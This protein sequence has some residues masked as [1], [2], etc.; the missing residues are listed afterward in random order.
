MALDVV[1]IEGCYVSSSLPKALYVSP[2]TRNQSKGDYG[3]RTSNVLYHRAKKKDSKLEE[4]LPVA[5]RQHLSVQTDLYLEE[6]CDVVD[7]VDVQCE[8]DPLL[9]RPAS[10]LFIPAKSGPD[11][12][13]QIYPGELFDFD[14]EVEPL[15][16]ALV[17]QT[18]EQAL[19]EIMAEEELAILLDMQN[20]F[21]SRRYAELA[22][23]KHLEE[24]ERIAVEQKTSLLKE[25][26]EAI[27]L[28][29][30]IAEKI[31]ACI[32]AQDYLSQLVPHLYERLEEQGYFETEEPD[33]QGVEEKFWPWLL[34]E[35][36]SEIAS[37]EASC[38]ILDS[39]L[40]NVVE[41][42]NETS[43]IQPAPSTMYP[44]IPQ[45]PPKEKKVAVTSEGNEDSLD[46]Q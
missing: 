28:E 15:L 46:E 2:H 8:T 34:N 37:I 24:R 4:V 23:L 32:F 1:R 26:E 6:L 41:D 7:E 19:I 17:G 30:E 3:R 13:T 39:L 9:D 18:I 14:Y 38:A 45:L 36:D 40:C 25:Q 11:K 21:D 16:E 33:V 42:I 29:N 22:E 5:G 12:E 10:P 44:H 20:K 27:K 43:V 35:V 31:A